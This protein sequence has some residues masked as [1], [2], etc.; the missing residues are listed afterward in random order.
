MAAFVVDYGVLWASRNQA[1][2]AADAGALSGA[3]AR[4]YDDFD[5]PPDPAGP[6]AQSAAAVAS[7][8]EVWSAASAPVTSF[9][10]PPDAAAPQR[11]VRVDVY[12]NGENGSA[13]LPTWF[14]R[15][16]GITSQGVKATATAQAMTANGTNCLRPWAIPDAWTEGVA[17]SDFRR[18]GV[19]GVPLTPFDNYVPPDTGGPG[20]G[21]RFA[22]SNANRYDLGEALAL[23]LATDPTNMA[24]AVD[25]IYPGWV[26]P[27]E[28]AAGYA[29]SI[30]SCNGE[31]VEIGDQIPVSLTM[32]S[33]ADFGG[34]YA[35]DPI[36]FWDRMSDSIRNSCAPA[37]APFSPRLVAVALFDT[38]IYQYRRILGNWSAC[39]PSRSSCTPCPGGAACATIVNI[40]GLFLDDAGSLA[41]LASYPGVVPTS[42]A[43]VSAQ[44]S[45]LKAITLVR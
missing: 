29:A 22:T 16:L 5:D 13:S 9:G 36:A 12:R 41:T 3:L 6:A 24:P 10:C 20:T 21:F 18:Y 39:P 11:C 34:L 40:A 45:F 19:G 15:V 33:A 31:S 1:Q 23:T 27:L 8:N 32:P 30:A 7:A 43:K 37:C 44:S 2:N 17:P 14:A 35:A 42:M 26:L 25:P 28:P 38:E 4:A